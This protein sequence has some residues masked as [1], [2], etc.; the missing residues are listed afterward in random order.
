MNQKALPMKVPPQ[1]VAESAANSPRNC[2]SR[3]TEN[4]DYFVC[5]RCM[6]CSSIILNLMNLKNKSPHQVGEI[7][8]T[9]DPMKIVTVNTVKSICQMRYVLALQA[10]TGYQGWTLRGVWPVHPGRSS[11]HFTILTEIF[12][13]FVRPSRVLPNS[14]FV[15]RNWQNVLHFHDVLNILIPKCH[16]AMYLVSLES[17]LKM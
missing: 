13:G 12:T 17:S 9:K 8:V 15:L 2:F 7:L 1:K 10:R 16:T 3:V 6:A 11:Y 14:H 5:F 4:I